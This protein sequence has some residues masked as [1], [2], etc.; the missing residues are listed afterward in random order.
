MRAMC[1]IVFAGTTP[2]NA[3]FLTPLYRQGYLLTLAPGDQFRA[4]ERTN[5]PCLVVLALAHSLDVLPFRTPNMNVAANW[6][7]WNQTDD[8]ALSVAAYDH[9]ALAVL[10]SAISPDGL[11]RAV[12]RALG[13][14]VHR[15]LPLAA[16]PPQ[17]R[18]FKRGEPILCDPAFVGIV[19]RGQ[20][21]QTAIH[22]DGSETVLGFLGAG[23]ILSGGDYKRY[24]VRF[25]A[26][27]DGQVLWRD[28]VGA[29]GDP[30]IGA[31]LRRQINQQ[32]V[33][34]AAQGHPQIARRILGIVHLLAETFGVPHAPGTLVDLR[35]T[36]SQLAAAVGATRSTV[37]RTLG[38]LRTAG[39]L[40]V[41][42]QGAG[43]RFC[44]PASVPV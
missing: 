26:H 41:V 18:R 28:W 21:I 14:S 13:Q 11:L 10:P 44:L 43:E 33:W 40:T 9:G 25:Y 20:I 4:L 19:E 30:A 15:V 27:T 7:A 29:A 38:E 2:P 12:Q 42:G 5:Q 36:H 3:A 31:A 37:T 8:P 1:H 22:S 23:A 6:L 24:A 34:A 16:P 39:A 32:Q 17:I 35:L